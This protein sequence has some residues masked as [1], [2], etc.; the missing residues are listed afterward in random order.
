MATSLLENPAKVAKLRLEGQRAFSSYAGM[1]R[2]AIEALKYANL[3]LKKEDTIISRRSKIDMPEKAIQKT[4][5]VK[6]KKTGLDEEVLD[7]DSASGIAVNALG[8]FIRI[9]TRFLGAEDEFFRQIVYRMELEKDILDKAIRN[10]LS[11]TKVVG[12]LENGK[13]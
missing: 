12:K 4:K 8:K 10:K 13:S 3:A 1:R 5:I 2:Y 11:K 7:W 6:N 9:P